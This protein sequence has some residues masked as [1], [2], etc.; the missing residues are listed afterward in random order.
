MTHES[1]QTITSQNRENGKEKK[2][3]NP[4]PSMKEERVWVPI[5]TKSLV[6]RKWS[7]FN[8]SGGVL[9]RTR[10]VKLKMYQTGVAELKMFRGRSFKGREG[11]A[12]PEFGVCG[13]MWCCCGF[14]KG[15][16]LGTCSS[17]LMRECFKR[18]GWDRK[19]TWPLG[20]RRDCMFWK[21]IPSPHNGHIISH[22]VGFI[23]HEREDACFWSMLN[24]LV[25]RSE[26]WV[27]NVTSHCRWVHCVRVFTI[28]PS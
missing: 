10:A 15:E 4:A 26:G 6:L 5:W 27:A 25:G 20:R 11:C 13:S 3:W 17:G 18:V 24:I 7:A 2:N 1:G 16:N 28:L 12:R 8:G 23:P 22:H 19:C 21:A 14:G 9:Y